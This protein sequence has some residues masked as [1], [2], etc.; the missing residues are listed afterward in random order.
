M[1][2]ASICRVLAHATHQSAFL[3]A[4]VA[5]SCLLHSTALA[6][7]AYVDSQGRTWRQVDETI[8]HTWTVVAQRC[9]TDGSTP[10]TGT[11]GNRDVTGWVWATDAQVA[12]MFE[13]FMPG[14]EEAGFLSGGICV[15]PGLGFLNTFRPTFASYTT[16]GASFYISGWSSTNGPQGATNALV[17]EVSA[18]YQPHHGSFNL[19]ASVSV[20][21]QS[22]YRGVWLFLPPVA[23]CAADFNSDSTLDV[24][25]V[26]AFLNAF[27]V[28]DASADWTNDGVF[29]FFDLLSF[30]EDFAAGCP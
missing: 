16:F 14:I 15:L 7:V 10:C 8:S 22:Q 21:T 26:F 13:E 19:L 17:P 29:D 3:L 5:A 12:E 1:N 18:G 28:L 30:L 9:P 27:A 25:D 20:S 24:F 6:D 4:A 11:L 2:A 23:P